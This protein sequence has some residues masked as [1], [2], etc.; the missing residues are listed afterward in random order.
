METFGMTFGL[1]TMGVNYELKK[2]RGIKKKS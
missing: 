1:R 2:R